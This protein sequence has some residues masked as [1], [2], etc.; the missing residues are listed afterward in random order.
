MPSFSN[1]YL[2]LG[3]ALGRMRYG[4]EPGLQP[5]GKTLVG[6]GN[7]FAYLYPKHVVDC[8]MFPEEVLY[9]FWGSLETTILDNAAN[10]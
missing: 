2:C 10:S 7:F 9:L 1:K 5:R 4:Q 3:V 8:R 6:T